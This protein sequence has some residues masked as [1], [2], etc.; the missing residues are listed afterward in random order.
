M[1]VN[2]MTHFEKMMIK[3]SCYLQI[4][5]FGG[6]AL[7]F[8]GD[9]SKEADVD[10]MIKTVSYFP[11]LTKLIYAIF[12]LLTFTWLYFYRRWMLGGLLIY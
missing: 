6:Q 11:F 3:L 8:G 4:E 7:T 5:G 2:L 1:M 9:V 12:L 10:A